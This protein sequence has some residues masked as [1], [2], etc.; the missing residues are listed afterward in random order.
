MFSQTKLNKKPCCFLQELLALAE[1]ADAIN[2]TEAPMLR[3]RAAFLA[4]QTTNHLWDEVRRKNEYLC[5]TIRIIK[6]HHL[7]K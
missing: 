7:P 5:R 6:K 4:N 2:R 3:A 1:L